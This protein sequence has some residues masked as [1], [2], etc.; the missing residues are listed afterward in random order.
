MQQELP[1]TIE[2]KHRKGSVKDPFARVALPFVFHAQWSVILINYD[3][4]VHLYS[5]ACII[6]R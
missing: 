1:L 6:L 2:D 4:S 5:A 3:Y